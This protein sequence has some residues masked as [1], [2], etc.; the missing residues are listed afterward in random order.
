MKVL[1]LL[2]LVAL[3][4]AFDFPEEWEAWKKVVFT[5]GIRDVAR[6]ILFFC[7]ALSSAEI[8]QAVL[9]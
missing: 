2:A 1:F 6:V 3:V 9:Q 5:S 4:A 8:W 7:A